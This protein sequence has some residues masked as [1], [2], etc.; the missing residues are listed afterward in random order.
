MKGLQGAVAS[1]FRIREL[2]AVQNKCGECKNQKDV[3]LCLAYFLSD[4]VEMPPLTTFK[5]L[6]LIR[7]KIETPTWE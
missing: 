5:E 4:F 2:V 1:G 7:E 3:L 6:V